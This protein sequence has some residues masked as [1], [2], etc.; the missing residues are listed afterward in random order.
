[1]LLGAVETQVFGLVWFSK[2]TGLDNKIT[3]HPF[4][5]PFLAHLGELLQTHVV[6]HHHPSSTRTCFITAY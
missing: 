3:R 4:S 6:P 1:M 2:L 5:R